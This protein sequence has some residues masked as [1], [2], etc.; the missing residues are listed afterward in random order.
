[1]KLKF[2]R[3]AGEQVIKIK[4][5]LDRPAWSS[6]QETGMFHAYK[7]KHCI[8]RGRFEL[9]KNFYNRKVR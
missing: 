1:M 8:V 2:N 9:I 6:E 4:A 3:K 7:H 5:S